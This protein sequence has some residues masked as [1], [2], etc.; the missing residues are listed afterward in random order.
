MGGWIGEQMRERG[1]CTDVNFKTLESYKLQRLNSCR[2][3]EVKLLLYG[4]KFGG[5]FI[6]LFLKS[7]SPV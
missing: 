7:C 3:S 6:G 2:C 5:N 4:L 1:I